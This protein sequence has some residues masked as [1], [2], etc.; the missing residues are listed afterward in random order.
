MSALRGIASASCSDGCM[1]DNRRLA[2][3]RDFMSQADNAW[4]VKLYYSFQDSKYL[5]LVTPTVPFRCAFLHLDA[6]FLSGY[7]VHA[8]G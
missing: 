5:Y 2:S 3:Y 1:R 6:L 4:V 8:R 7:G